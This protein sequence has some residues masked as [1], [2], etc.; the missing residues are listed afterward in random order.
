MVGDIY[1]F[2]FNNGGDKLKLMDVVSWGASFF[3]D[4]SSVNVFAGCSNL[5]V[6][7]QENESIGND[8]AIAN[9]VESRQKSIES[10]PVEVDPL[11]YGRYSICCVVGTFATGV[12]VIIVARD[13][14]I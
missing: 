10:I 1:G 11:L 5:R 6:S 7:F 14:V 13:F 8:S 3:M 4:S 12:S 9:T 2:R